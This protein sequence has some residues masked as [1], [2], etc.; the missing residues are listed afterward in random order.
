[1]K[2]FITVCAPGFYG[3]NVMGHTSG[4]TQC[5]AG[6]FSEAGAAPTVHHC[7]ACPDGEWGPPGATSSDGCTSMYHLIE[8][9][10][11]Y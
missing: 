10:I 3:Q 4:C 7:E 1:M 6:T 5:P 2:T 8:E 11:I 9:W